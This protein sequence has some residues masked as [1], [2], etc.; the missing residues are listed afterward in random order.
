MTT[1]YFH[2]FRKISTVLDDLAMMQKELSNDKIEGKS[3]NFTSLKSILN[4]KL[5]LLKKDVSSLPSDD[6]HSPMAISLRNTN[7]EKITE[8]RD[9]VDKMKKFAQKPANDEDSITQKQLTILYMREVDMCEEKNSYSS[10]TQMYIPRV[11][12]SRRNKD[13]EDL[14]NN[15][16]SENVTAFL[17]R[18][19]L[20][21]M[22]QDQIL[23]DI[24]NGVTVLETMSKS[25]RKELKLQNTIIDTVDVKIDTVI[26]KVITEEE[27]LKL[28]IDK[29]GGG[30]LQHCTRIVCFIFLLAAIGIIVGMLKS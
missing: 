29:S 19:E 7:R 13:V 20:T 17:Q 1:P 25:I 9:L 10:T 8:C 15:E 2:S 5:K 14:D 16:D 18:V 26:E 3:N 27:K 21:K 24:L 23:D 6:E 30:I 12:R 4:E 28:L 22:E 11:K